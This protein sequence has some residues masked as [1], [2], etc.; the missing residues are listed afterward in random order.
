MTSQNGETEILRKLINSDS[1]RYIIDV[2][3]NDGITHSN[4]YPFV[5]DGWNCLAIEANPFVYQ[6]LQRN[7]AHYKN[8]V[9]LNQACS[10][11]DNLGN[12]YIGSDGLNGMFSTL[13]NDNNSWFSFSRTN[14]KIPV[15]ISRLETILDGQNVPTDFSILMVD[16][17]GM[18][19]E[20]LQGLN[21]HK[22]KPKVIITENYK[23]NLQKHDAKFQL[24]EQHGYVYKHKV[25]CN[26]IWVRGGS[27]ESVQSH[28][29]DVRTILAQYLVNVTD[30]K[31]DF[32]SVK[33]ILPDKYKLTLIKKPKWEDDALLF[34]VEPQSPDLT[35]SWTVKIHEDKYPLASHVYDSKELLHKLSCS[36]NT[37]E[38]LATQSVEADKLQFRTVIYE[39]LDGTPLDK[40]VVNADEQKL[41]TLRDG[42]KKCVAPLLKQG[43][44]V[45]VRDLGDF[46]VTQNNRVYLTDFNAIMDCSNSNPYSRERVMEI[47]SSVIDKLIS[48]NY[49]PFISQRPTM[50]ETELDLR[51]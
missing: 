22:Y 32:D 13:C 50:L 11:H 14:Q 39:Y 17:E 2:G 47:V 23:H 36:G 16:T 33:S 44:N 45:F 37:T 24:L 6:R 49:K 9:T 15:Q 46:L 30:K 27:S 41:D 51:F 3:A 5:Q 25:G 18:D 8:A 31:L 35:Y 20:V 40:M 43:I 34:K 26:T 42:L 29:Q 19:Y 21:F 10:N 48:Q 12:L 4:S 28:L 7:L 38:I 1:Q